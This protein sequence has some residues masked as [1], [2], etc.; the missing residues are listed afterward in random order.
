M[1]RK[2]TFR[3]QLNAISKYIETLNKSIIGEVIYNLW[4]LSIPHFCC[5]CK[6][7]VNIIWLK[8]LNFSKH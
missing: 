3:F 1:Y 2:A 7:L 8:E 5:K 6:P 4:Q